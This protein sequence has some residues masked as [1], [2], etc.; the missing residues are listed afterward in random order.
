MLRSVHCAVIESWSRTGDAIKDEL[1][2]WHRHG[3]PNLMDRWIYTWIYMF[4]YACMVA[5]IYSVERFPKRSSISL[6]VV[7]FVCNLA[8]LFTRR[9]RD[10]YYT[11][12]S[13]N[14]YMRIIVAGKSITNAMPLAGLI[15]LSISPS[16]RLLYSFAK[17]KRIRNTKSYWS[18]ISFAAAAAWDGNDSCCPAGRNKRKRKK[19]VDNNGMPLSI[20]HRCILTQWMCV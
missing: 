4:L 11:F 15:N 8:S 1:N 16:S 10:Y 13:E 2:V 6:L 17:S 20:P 7:R 9:E 5:A 12:Q 3:R 14:I 19:K 18:L